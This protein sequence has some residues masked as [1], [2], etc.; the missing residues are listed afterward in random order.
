MQYIKSLEEKDGKNEIE[1]HNN[2]IICSKCLIDNTTE[3]KD[4]LA[5]IK[6]I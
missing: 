6:A 4:N 3:K 5:D 2:Q 1:N